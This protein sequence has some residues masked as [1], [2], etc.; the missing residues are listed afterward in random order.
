MSDWPDFEGLRCHILKTGTERPQ[1][2]LRVDELTAKF[3]VQEPA[4]WHVLLGMERRRLITLSRWDGVRDQ[5]LAIWP[6]T[7][8]FMACR[9]DND[10]V[11][12]I[13]RAEGLD[14]LCEGRI[15]GAAID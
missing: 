6:S 14:F 8:A 4:V 3:S 7:D 9:E 13:T 2:R 5:P 10:K 11:R 12:V 1:G 15:D